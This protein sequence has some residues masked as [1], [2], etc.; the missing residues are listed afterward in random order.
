[1]Q[2]LQTRGQ[3]LAFSPLSFSPTSTE[4]FIALAEHEELTP[5]SEKKISENHFN[6][7]LISESFMVNPPIHIL[8]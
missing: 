8:F 1:M 7:I 4:L 5:Q 2:L 6:V 3:T